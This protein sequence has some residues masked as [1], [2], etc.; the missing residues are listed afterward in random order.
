MR[1]SRRTAVSLGR[2]HHGGDCSNDLFVNVT[3]KLGGVVVSLCLAASTATYPTQVWASE[4]MENTFGYA[5]AGL[6]PSVLELELKPRIEE[7][8]L[9]TNS[10]HDK[11][12]YSH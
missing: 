8:I 4:D 5:D 1:E 11:E 3:R 2:K 6:E 10:D 7:V 12:D 9:E